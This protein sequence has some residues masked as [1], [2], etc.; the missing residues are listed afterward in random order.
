M[1]RSLIT[2]GRWPQSGSQPE[3]IQWL[4]LA[5]EENALLCL[6]AAIL[7]CQPYHRE[8]GPATWAGCSLRRWLNQDFFFAAFS[9]EELAEAALGDKKRAG[10]AITLVVPEKIGRCTMRTVPVGELLPV[11]R[12][13]MG[14]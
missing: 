10:D 12:A 13:G 9:P 7:D 6:S 1:E 3:P 11:I 5:E 4:V 2:L 14:R 8:G